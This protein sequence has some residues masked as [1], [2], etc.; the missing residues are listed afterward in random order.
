MKWICFSVVY[1]CQHKNWWVVLDT[2]IDIRNRKWM[3]G[4]NNRKSGLLRLSVKKLTIWIIR[5]NLTLFC[6][7]RWPRWGTACL[8]ACSHQSR[9]R[10]IYA[11][12][13]NRS[14]KYFLL[15]RQKKLFLEACFR[16][17]A[18]KN[19]RMENYEMRISIQGQKIFFVIVGM[20]RKVPLIGLNKN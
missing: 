18:A 9:L 5:M 19:Y 3:K 16:I 8:P 20:N 10:K 11:L 14:E 7:R 1:A 17:T 2:Y 4:N 15:I 13:T 6:S 12:K